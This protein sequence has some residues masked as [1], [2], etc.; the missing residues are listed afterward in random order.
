MRDL[1]VY[2]GAAVLGTLTGMRSMSAPAVMGQLSRQGALS[3]ENGHLDYMSGPAFASA[4]SLLALGEWVADKLPVTPNRTAAGPLLGRAIV[5]GA[6]GAVL[7]AAKGRSAWGGALIGA[8]T[9]VGAAFAA[10]E[11]R[12]RIKGKLHVPDAFVALA[13]NLVVISLSTAFA[14]R[15]KTSAR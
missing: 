13:E 12:K 2:A 4:T 5:G 8:A 9:A 10:Y 3:G 15:F 14:S 6:S 11:L 1:D 7:C